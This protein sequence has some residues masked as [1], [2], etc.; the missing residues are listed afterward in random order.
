LSQSRT[1]AA[2]TVERA[3]I[4]WLASRGWRV[5]AIAREVRLNGDSVRL[6]L[7]RFNDDGLDGLRD[8]PRAG[9]PATYTAE[10]A[11]EVVAL[12]LTDPRSLDLPFASWTLDRLTAYLHE[13]KRIPM[14]RAR[15]G[16]LLAAEGLRWRTQETWFGER[17]DPDFARKRG[18]SKP[19]TAPHPRAAS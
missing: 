14:S 11:G 6:W 9:R 16:K 4:I 18:R 2:R 13:V 12:S 7:K 1:A 19:S 5:P 3:K 8:R 17:V 15:I 10:Q